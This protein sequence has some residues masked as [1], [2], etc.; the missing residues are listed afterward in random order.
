MATAPEDPLLGPD[1]DD[2]SLSGSES[3]SDS[4]LSDDSVLPDY[5]REITNGRAASTLYQACA[6]NDLTALRRVLERGVTRDE[7]MELDINSWVRDSF[8]M[9]I[10][11]NLLRCF[12]HCSTVS[13]I[14]TVN[15]YQQNGLMLACCK[16]FVDI[17]YQLQNCPH[18][19]I[20]HQDNE[21]NT[22]LMI[23]SQAGKSYTPVMFSFSSFLW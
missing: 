5:E 14:L 23:A 6:R 19:D 11:Q 12:K 10:I 1:E 21:G 16:G 7:V 15:I 8:T 17:V 18:I 9:A 22:A 13:L 4:V 3:D 2:D 20:N